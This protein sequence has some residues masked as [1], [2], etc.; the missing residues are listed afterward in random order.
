MH[1]EN[2][3]NADDKHYVVHKLSFAGALYQCAGLIQDFFGKPIEKDAILLQ[4]LGTALRETPTYGEDV[5]LDIVIKNIQTIITKHT[6]EDARTPVIVITDLRYPNEFDR[7]RA[8]GFHL[9][10]IHRK[11]RPPIGR[12]PNHLS[13][14]ALDNHTFEHNI[15]NDGSI[16]EFGEKIYELLRFLEH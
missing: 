11:D 4:K 8:E 15:N 6:F 3:Y 13:E 9:I 7:L 12:D 16:E 10:K 2:Y 1:I 5:W 14:I